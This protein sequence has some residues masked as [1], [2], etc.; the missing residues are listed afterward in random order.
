MGV[1]ELP[2]LNPGRLAPERVLSHHTVLLLST[3]GVEGAHLCGTRNSRGVEYLLI[4]GGA[5]GRIPISKVC[6]RSQARDLPPRTQVLATH[7]RTTAS[8]PSPQGQP[9]YWQD[10]QRSRRGGTEGGHGLRCPH[11]LPAQGGRDVQ[12]VLRARPSQGASAC[13]QVCAGWRH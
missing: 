3:R 9:S 8:V 11:A 12:E 4:L 13:G 1:T 10:L 2:S 7:F 5:Q 6:R